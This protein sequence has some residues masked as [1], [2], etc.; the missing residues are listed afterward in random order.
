MATLVAVGASDADRDALREALA[1]VERRCAVTLLDDVLVVRWLGAG[2]Q[3]GL[4]VLERAWS[5]LRPR[6]LGREP[7][8]PRIWGT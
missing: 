2:A 4:S 6:L 1:G 3:E 5:L 7:C 8:P